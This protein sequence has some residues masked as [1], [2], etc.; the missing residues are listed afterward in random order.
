MMHASPSKASIYRDFSRNHSPLIARGSGKGRASWQRGGKRSL[1]LV[2]SLAALVALLPLFALVCCL[3]FA[4]GRGPVLYRHGRIGLRGRPFQCL[5]F[6]TMH[7]DGDAV[8][9]KHLASDPEARREWDEKQ[10]LRDDPRVTVIGGILRRTS[11]DEL[12]QL[13]NIIRGDM[14]LVGPRPVT[15]QELTRYGVA[16][17]EYLSVRPGLT[18]LWQVSGRSDTSYA[19]RVKLDSEYVR[20]QSLLGDARIMLLTVPVVLMQRGSV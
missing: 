11:L 14:S 4:S 17:S 9:S 13:I 10:K 3:I 5:K 12:P 7:I 8:L 19:S 15:A 20:N 1:D 18:G 16:A 2:L 6:R